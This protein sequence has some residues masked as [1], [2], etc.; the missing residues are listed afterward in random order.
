[1][2]CPQIVVLD[3]GKVVEAGRHAELLAKRGKYAD[4]WE[5]QATVDD[6]ASRVD[7]AQAT[8]L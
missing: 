6:A 5:K 2:R 7:N 4:M 1:M 8:A 3:Q